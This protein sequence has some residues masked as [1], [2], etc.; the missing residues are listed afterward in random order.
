MKIEQKQHILCEPTKIPLYIDISEKIINFVENNINKIRF[1]KNINTM[2]DNK[3]DAVNK[4]DIYKYNNNLY[5]CKIN[6]MHFYET[7]DLEILISI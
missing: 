6:F 3:M 7:E 2:N 5:K 4:F 1:P